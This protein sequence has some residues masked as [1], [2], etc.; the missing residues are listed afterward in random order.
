MELLADEHEKV[1]RRLTNAQEALAAVEQK[2]RSIEETLRYYC[3][4]NDLPY[5]NKEIDDRL[6]VK[7][8]GM[9]ALE[10]IQSIARENHG[11]VAANEV[12]KT[13][14]RAALYAHE[15]SA[16]GSV[17]GMLN[18]HP[19]LFE[20]ISPG[21]YRLVEEARDPDLGVT[22]RVVVG[23]PDPRTSSEKEVSV[24]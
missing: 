2:M 12:G 9:S 20:K 24:V 14:L 23:V 21:R 10:A 6:R 15:R 16:T 19:E 4:V 8:H 11:I 7:F 22:Q 3:E 5:E 13:L 18:R 1:S 17:Y